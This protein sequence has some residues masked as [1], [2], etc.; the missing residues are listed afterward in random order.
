MTVYQWLCLLGVPALIAAIFKYLHSLVKKNA[1][2]TAAVK[3]GLQALLRSQ[4]ISDYN[5]W[6]ERL[7]SYL[8]PGK[9]RELLEAVPLPQRERRYGRPP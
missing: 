1:L 5:K 3:A 9:L 6:E 4:M 8:R 7:R 2:D